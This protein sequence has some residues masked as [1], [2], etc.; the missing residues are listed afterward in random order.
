[1][2]Q[3]NKN[4][5][6]WHNFHISIYIS[7][8]YIRARKWQDL[9]YYNILLLKNNKGKNLAIKKLLKRQHTCIYKQRLCKDT[10]TQEGHKKEVI[11]GL[12]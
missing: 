10:C 3:G 7:C 8:I 12:T 4:C 1:M 6:V 2:S 5:S 9:D 11:L